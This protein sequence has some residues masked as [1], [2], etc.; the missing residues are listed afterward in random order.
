MK[1]LLSF[2][3]IAVFILSFSACETPKEEPAAP[4]ISDIPDFFE[5]PV[6][7]EDQSV[8]CE[9]PKE[10]FTISLVTD[11]S[12]SAPVTK[13]IKDFAPPKFVS[14]EETAMTGRTLEIWEK[15]ISPMD[16]FMPLSL[17]FD[18]NNAPNGNIAIYS[19]IFYQCEYLDSKYYGIEKSEYD[20]AENYWA[21][22]RK[23]EESIARWFPWSP[24]DY[25]RYFEYDAKTDKYFVPGCGGGVP[26]TYITDYR[27][28]G[29]YLTIDFSYYDGW[30]ESEACQIFSSHTLKIKLEETGWKY[31]SNKN[32]YE[33]KKFFNWISK[34]FT[35]VA[36]MNNWN[37]GIDGEFTVFNNNKLHLLT[38]FGATNYHFYLDDTPCA[39]F[40]SKSG[41]LIYDFGS[42]S[43][44][45]IKELP[46]FCTKIHETTDAV[47]ENK[48]EITIYYRC[49][50]CHE[51]YTAILDYETLEVKNF[52]H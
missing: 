33:S 18:E 42:N 34:D 48:D 28:D 52:I 20:M 8:A 22:G 7:K 10:I 51:D 31:L 41:V 37:P 11:E 24:E 9:E 36:A 39:L 2:L 14:T 40:P 25:R 47:I 13:E 49:T 19:Y 15:Y 16:S 44:R 26:Y 29:D 21:D 43:T 12:I 32:T 30:A 35:A 3:L 46:S 5:E 38:V 23:T 50:A 17:D 1:K 27:I 4:T 45:C 6:L